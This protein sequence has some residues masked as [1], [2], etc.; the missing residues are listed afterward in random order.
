MR[1]TRRL[2]VLLA[3]ASVVLIACS[4]SSSSS[5]TTTTTKSPFPFDACYVVP[6]AAAGALLQGPV[7]AAAPESTERE[8]ARVS[9]CRYAQS[10]D[11]TRE[12]Q[13]AVQ[14][15][16]GQAVTR[17]AVIKSLRAEWKDYQVTD[18]SGVGDAALFARGPVLSQIAALQGDYFIIVSF[19][20]TVQKDAAVS[21]AKDAV[22]RLPRSRR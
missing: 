8:D 5:R 14:Q 20:N 9:K 21:V 16:N 17:D 10:S 12:V 11:P 13:V 22:S 1:S 19:P 2:A 18:V 4:S 6:A 15:Q 7:G 3:V